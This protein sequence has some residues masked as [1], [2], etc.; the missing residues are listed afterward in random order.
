MEQALTPGRDVRQYIR[1]PSNGPSSSLTALLSASRYIPSDPLEPDSHSRSNMRSQGSQPQLLGG[2]LLL[3]DSTGEEYQGAPTPTVTPPQAPSLS[4]LQYQKDPTPRKGKVRTPGKRPGRPPKNI[5]VNM[6]E[7]SK[8]RRRRQVR[9][10]Q[11]AYRLRGT[12]HVE[13]LEDRITELEST[14]RN[15]SEAVISFGDCVAQ[16]GLLSSHESLAKELRQLLQTC[17]T[18]TTNAGSTDDQE[19]FNSPQHE[20]AVPPTPPPSLSNLTPAIN[21]IVHLPLPGEPTPLERY[22]LFYPQCSSS[23]SA[24]NFSH[25]GFVGIATFAE[26]HW[27]AEQSALAEVRGSVG[28]M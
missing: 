9:L 7:D 6:D 19:T 14:V 20:E 3:Q 13:S 17:V 23:P 11:R 24:F 28:A 15:M 10:A 16:S 1:P 27:S 5:D 25:K 8:D 4:E 26:Q 12:A 18:S 22:G 2:L 21:N